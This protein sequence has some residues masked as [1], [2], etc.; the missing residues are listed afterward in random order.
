MLTKHLFKGV[1]SLAVAMGNG[2]RL[3]TNARQRVSLSTTKEIVINR[4][5]RIGD[6]VI[7]KPLLILFHQYALERNSSL[8]MHILAS[9][10]NYEVLKDIPGYSVEVKK[11][12]LHE[13]PSMI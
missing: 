11:T 1:F 7:T 12:E 8:H 4:S 6:A 5:D 9:S 3:F 10:L 2:L 13:N